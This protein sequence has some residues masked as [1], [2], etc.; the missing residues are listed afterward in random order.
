MV[1]LLMSWDIKPGQE[2]AYFEFILQ[3]FTPTMIK[4]GIRPIEAWYTIYGRGPQ[5]LTGGVVEDLETLKRILESE[6]WRS[7]EKRLKRFVTNFQRKVVPASG[8]FQL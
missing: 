1:K 6:E 4:L 7:L 8:H 3:E 2:N 5:I